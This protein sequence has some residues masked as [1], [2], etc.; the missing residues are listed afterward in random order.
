MIVF[1]SYIRMNGLKTASSLL[2]ETGEKP[3]DT[4][5]GNERS[6]RGL[7]NCLWC[8]LTAVSRLQ[9]DNSCASWKKRA[10]LS[11]YHTAAHFLVWARL[12]SHLI[13]SVPEYT[14]IVP[15]TTL[16]SSGTVCETCRRAECLR[17]HSSNEEDFGVK[18]A[19]IWASCVKPP[20]I[21]HQS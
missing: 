2:K 9:G 7:A 21:T 12:L 19:R 20:S 1:I 11:A 13:R 18:S 15:E 16:T 14:W 4:D 10:M 5:T 8:K 6:V 3:C 17:S